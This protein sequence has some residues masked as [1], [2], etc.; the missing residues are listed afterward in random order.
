V[1]NIPVAVGI[2]SVEFPV[3]PP[4][5]AEFDLALL[6]QGS[7]DN[8]NPFAYLSLV[9]PGGWLHFDGVENLRLSLGFQEELIRA[10]PSLGIKDSQ[11][12]RGM[13]RA[14]L[15]Q[16]RGQAALY[17]MTQLDVR[18]F[19]DPAGTHRVVFRP[20]FRLGQGFNLDAVRIHSLVLYEEVAFQFAADDY[21]ARPFSF[22]RTVA[23]YTWTTRRGTFVTLGIVGQVSLNAPATRYDVFWG[24]VLAFSH[25]F[26][27]TA[28]ETPP[29]PPE[30]DVQ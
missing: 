25:R 19:D 8:R 2:A 10:V 14:R 29:E 5:A 26:R 15:Q 18:S 6:G 24:P 21:L 28:P 4:F 1:G 23:G 30:V 9:Q 17:E 22:F 3:S 12:E 11:E 7:Y 16:P 20:R 27:S 13:A